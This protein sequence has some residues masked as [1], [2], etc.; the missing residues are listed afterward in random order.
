LYEVNEQTEAD[1]QQLLKEYIDEPDNNLSA[2]QQLQ[3]YLESIQSTAHI[4]SG[5]TALLLRITPQLIGHNPDRSKVVTIKQIIYQN[6]QLQVFISVVE[7]EMIEALRVQ[8]MDSID[9]IEIDQV[10]IRDGATSAR[11]RLYE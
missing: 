2:E 7:S 3:D 6:D 10:D 4:Q 11:I 9:Q 5:F 1:I 8:L